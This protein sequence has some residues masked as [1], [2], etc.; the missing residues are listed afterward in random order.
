MLQSLPPKYAVSC[1]SARKTISGDA[2]KPI[3]IALV[4]IRLYNDDDAVRLRR[5]VVEKLTKY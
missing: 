3:V 1:V 5:E 2:K 4:K